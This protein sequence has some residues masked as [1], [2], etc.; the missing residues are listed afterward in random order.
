MRPRSFKESCLH[1]TL[2]GPIDDFKERGFYYSFFRIP[3]FAL[4]YTVGVF[5]AICMD[6]IVA[7]SDT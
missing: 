7:F 5:M 4:V 2:M 3:Y 6:I 1:E